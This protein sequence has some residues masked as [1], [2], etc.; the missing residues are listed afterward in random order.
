ML[1]IYH[2]YQYKNH[3]AYT[4]THIHTHLDHVHPSE[5]SGV[6]D[7]RWQRARQHWQ[8]S[9]CWLRQDVASVQQEAVQR[10]CILFG[11]RVVYL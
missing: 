5:W 6:S 8:R 11:H 1:L 2:I 9:T 4:H 7:E 10:D 3:R